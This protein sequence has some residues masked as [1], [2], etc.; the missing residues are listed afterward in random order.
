MIRQLDIPPRI[1]QSYRRMSLTSGL[2]SSGTR[3]PSSVAGTVA[4]HSAPHVIITSP[5]EPTTAVNSVAVLSR[6]TTSAHGLAVSSQR[7]LSS[8]SSNLPAGPPYSVSAP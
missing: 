8:T 1:F 6:W 2:R 5:T 4:L 7:P 3:M